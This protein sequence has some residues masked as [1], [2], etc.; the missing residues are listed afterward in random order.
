M[1]VYEVHY[2]NHL[3]GYLY[4]ENGLHRYTPIV[5]TVQMLQR[6]AFLLRE[7]TV[8][9]PWGKPIPFFDR[10]ICNNRN[11]GREKELYSH[12]NN[13]VLRLVSA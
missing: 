11:A 10:M 9:Y 1:I 7:T 4:I 8:D 5:Q 6:E 3:L 13:Y 12:N 2:R